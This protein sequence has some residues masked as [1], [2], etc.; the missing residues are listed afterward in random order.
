MIYRWL[1]SVLPFLQ[2]GSQTQG[3]EPVVGQESCSTACNQSI[4][5]M[6]G[7]AVSVDSTSGSYVCLASP[8][9]GYNNRFGTTVEESGSGSTACTYA[10]D[11]TATADAS[12]SCLCLFSTSST[13]AL[14]KPAVALPTAG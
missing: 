8:E 4:D 2:E 11:G 7:S 10:A 5:G 13:A 12:F 14:M 6:T 3:L 9:V 1:T